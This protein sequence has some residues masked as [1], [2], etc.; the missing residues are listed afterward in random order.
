M[1]TVFSH[2]GD[3]YQVQYYRYIGRRL[4]LTDQPLRYHP[5]V[6]T[7]GQPPDMVRMIMVTGQLT[8][9]VTVYELELFSTDECLVQQVPTKRTK[10]RF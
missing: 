8:P 1:L 5:I 2:T 10:L 4:R 9:P 7:E 3:N 6:S